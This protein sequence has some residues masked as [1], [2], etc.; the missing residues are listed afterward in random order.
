MHE[1]THTHTHTQSLPPAKNLR[2]KIMKRE[3]S[4]EGKTFLSSFIKFWTKDFFF[5]LYQVLLLC[6]YFIVGMERESKDKKSL[7]FI[8]LNKNHLKSIELLHKPSASCQQLT[9][10]AVESAGLM[11]STSNAVD[12]SG[13]HKDTW[14]QQKASSCLT[15]KLWYF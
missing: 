3:K 7:N 14:L 6:D 11:A 1:Y 4:C 15:S 9:T 2:T 10:F 5:I 8:N 13:S 12:A